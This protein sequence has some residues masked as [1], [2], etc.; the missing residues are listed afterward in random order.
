MLDIVERIKDIQVEGQKY[1][2]NVVVL[3][4]A[5]CYKMVNWFYSITT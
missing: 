3:A 4:M 1:P 2:K 5:A